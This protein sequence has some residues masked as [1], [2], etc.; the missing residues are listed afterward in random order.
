[1]RTRKENASNRA[2]KKAMN[3]KL[4]A[5]TVAMLLLSAPAMAQIFLDDESLTYRDGWLGQMDSIGNIIP[6]HEVDWDQ[7]SYTPTGGGIMLLGLLG[8]AYLVGKR[9]K[10]DQ[11]D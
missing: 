11:Q 3:K 9:R 2:M 5:L 10:E 1:M 4:A 8:G 6:F 7:A